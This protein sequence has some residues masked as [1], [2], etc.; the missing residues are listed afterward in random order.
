MD[1]G[2]VGT[3]HLCLREFV[4]KVAGAAVSLVANLKGWIIAHMAQIPVPVPT[5]RTRYTELLL[6]L[7]GIID[8]TGRDTLPGLCPY[9][10]A[11]GRVCPQ[12]QVSRRSGWFKGQRNLGTSGQGRGRT[13]LMSI[14]SFCASSFEPL[15]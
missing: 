11:R 9:L 13:Y 6:E 10:E 15:H 7:A 14:D 4:R 3:D 2:D 1:R 5:S 12:D 8:A